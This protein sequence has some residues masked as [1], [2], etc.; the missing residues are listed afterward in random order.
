[1]RQ[2]LRVASINPGIEV[3]DGVA[4]FAL[5]PGGMLAVEGAHW[6]FLDG[7][8][9]LLPTRLQLGGA[10]ERRFAL[11]V[12]GIDA[13]KF[14]LH[15]EISNLAATG[16]F[17]GRVP[18]VFDRNGGRIEGGELHARPPGGSL[19]YVGALSYKDLTPMANYAF[20]ALR[21]LK[22]REMSIGLGGNIAGEIVTRV[23]IAGIS[24]G[25]GA[26]RNFLTRQV[27]RLPL[28]F[29][30][31]IRAPFYQLVTSFKSFYD[32]SYVADPRTLG[33]MGADGRAI[34]EPQAAP[35]PAPTIQPSDSE[36][37]P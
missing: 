12:S 21:A 2:H 4:T 19:S 15:L 16:H 6:P 10:V 14:L 27:A 28:R 1:P 17:D 29:N 8:L 25:K 7:S 35:T 9:D 11:Q 3:T 26:S 20:R 32:S 24:Q 37:H 18:L 36:H 30:V 23:S 33:L 34:A 22:Y 13:A 5:E 31:N